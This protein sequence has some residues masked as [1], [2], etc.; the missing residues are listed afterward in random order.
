MIEKVII[1]SFIVFAIWYSMRPDEI[2]G[3]LG[4][5]LEDHLPDKFH[6]PLFACPVCMGGFY[7]AILYW[8]IFHNGVKEWLIVNI[9]TIGFNAIISKMFP[10]E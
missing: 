6:P 4:D 2:F 9:A 5:W 7:G 8:A 3:E 10:D 1:I